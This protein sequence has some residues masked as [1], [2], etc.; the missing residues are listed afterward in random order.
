[1]AADA[2]NGDLA[3]LSGTWLTV[4]IV[5]DGKTLV[6]DNIPAKEGPV[7]KLTYDGN[8][9]MVIVGD[10]TVATGMFKV[11]AT[12]TPKELDVLD[13]SGT[14]NDKTKRAIY[15]LNGT[16]TG[17]ASLVPDNLGRRSSRANWELGTR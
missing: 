8:K 13:E 7:T 12:R 1:V 10:K 5:S 16:L 2:P 15:E 17:T 9:W 3:K 11:D 4:S 6:G 14:I